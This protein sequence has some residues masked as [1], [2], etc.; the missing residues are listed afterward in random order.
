MNPLAVV[1]AV[2]GLAFAPVAGVVFA[3]GGSVAGGMGT[4]GIAV[5]QAPVRPLTAEQTAN[6][7][8]IVDVGERLAVPSYGQVVAVATA[9]QESGLRDLPYGD[10]DSL[11]L[12]QQ[13]PSQGWGSPSQLLD[14]AYAATGFYDQLLAVPGWQSMTLTQA[15]QAVQRSAFPDAYARWQSEATAIVQDLAGGGLGGPVPTA[16]SGAP[17]GGPSTAPVGRPTTVAGACVLA[18]LTP[19][20]VGV[21]V[22]FAAAQVGK[23]YVLGATGPDAWDCSAL[24][25]AA[26]AAAAV[27]LPRTADEQYDFARAHGEVFTGP[28]ASAHLQAGDLLFSPG[29]DPVP[30]ADGTPIGHVAIYAGNGVVVEAKGVAWGV[31]STVYPAAQYGDVTF[32]GR[33]VAPQASGP[34]SS[35]VP[36]APAAP[37]PSSTRKALP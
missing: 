13:R 20:A 9:L 12:F 3:G 37:T 31:I 18:D 34:P 36:G 8:V 15:A 32:V 23:L 33:L 10:G 11:G 6:A 26:Y 7:T 24:A 35:S 5:A 17:A 14:P 25:Q 16:A 28:Q 2:I 22:S 19:D 4:C 29:D 1:G 27:A 30:A 21:V